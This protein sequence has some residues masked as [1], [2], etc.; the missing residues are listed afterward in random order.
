M[1]FEDRLENLWNNPKKIDIETTFL[2]Y[3]LIADYKGNKYNYIGKARNKKRLK[4]YNRNMKKISLG[5]ERGKKQNYRAIHFVLFKALKEN[6]KIEFYPLENC[7]KDEI[8]KIEKERISKCKCNLNGA[9]TWR[10]SN[11]PLTINELLKDV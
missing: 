4:E 2:Y 9:K 7:S 1:N 10:L 5:K 6:W 3:I 8:N 11:I